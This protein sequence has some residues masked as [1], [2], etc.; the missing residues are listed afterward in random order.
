MSEASWRI[1]DRFKMGYTGLPK[2]L[3]KSEYKLSWEG[4]PAHLIQ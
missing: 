1:L 3:E 4:V 2:M